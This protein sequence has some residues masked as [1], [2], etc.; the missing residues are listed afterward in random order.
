M[1]SGRARSS[2]TAARASAAY[3]PTDIGSASGGFA[4]CPAD[5]E[6][7]HVE[8]RRVQDLRVGE[9]PVARR[10]PAVDQHDAGRSAGPAGRYQPGSRRPSVDGISTSS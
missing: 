4:P 6:R 2:A 7:Q 3:S 5:V 9:R 8:A 10:L 1:T